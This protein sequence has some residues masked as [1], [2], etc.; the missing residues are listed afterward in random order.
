MGSAARGGS[1]VSTDKQAAESARAKSSNVQTPRI[2]NEAFNKQNQRYQAHQTARS[3]SGEAQNYS[4]TGSSG[5]GFDYGSE[6]DAYTS[7]NSSAEV[8]S[9]VSGPSSGA[10]TD[11]RTAAPSATT[12]RSSDAQNAN[13]SG[14]SGEMRKSSDK[15][16]FD[17]DRCDISSMTARNKKAGAADSKPADMSKNSANMGGASSS[18]SMNANAKSDNKSAKSGG[19]NDSTRN[20]APGAAPRRTVSSTASG[21]VNPQHDTAQALRREQQQQQQQKEQA[22]SHEREFGQNSGGMGGSSYSAQ[23]AIDKLAREQSAHAPN[24]EG[25]RGKSWPQGMEA[26][27]WWAVD[28]PKTRLEYQRAFWVA[29]TVV[30][31]DKSDSKQQGE[32]A[33]DSAAEAVA[34]ATKTVKNT[35]SRAAERVGDAIKPEARA[36]AQYAKANAQEAMKYAKSAASAT[37][38]AA[39]EAASDLG[40]AAA[41][42]ASSAAETVKETVKSTVSDAAHKASSAAESVKDNVK[43]TVADAAHGVADAAKSA[44]HAGESVLHSASDAVGRAASKV[45]S[46]VHAGKDKIEGAAGAVADKVDELVNGPEHKQQKASTQCTRSAG[47]SQEMQHSGMK[48]DEK[49]HMYKPDNK[50]NNTSSY[51]GSTAKRM[52]SSYQSAGSSQTAGDKSGHSDTGGT[53]SGYSGSDTSDISGRDKK[54]DHSSVHMRKAHCTD[55]WVKKSGLNPK[56]LRDD[57]FHVTE[58]ERSADSSG[59]SPAYTDSHAV[60]E[61]GSESAKPASA[62][63]LSASGS[64]G[65][66]SVSTGA[67]ADEHALA[68]KTADAVANALKD[69]LNKALNDPALALTAAQGVV[70]VFSGSNKKGSVADIV[71]FFTGTSDADKAGKVSHTARAEAIENVLDSFAAAAGAAT[72]RALKTTIGGMPRAAQASFF[73]NNVTRMIFDRIATTATQ[74]LKDTILG[75]S[76]TPS[77]V[78]VRREVAAPTGSTDNSGASTLFSLIPSSVVETLAR[79]AGPAIAVALQTA[80]AASLFGTRAP[81]EGGYAQPSQE[82]LLRLRERVPSPSTFDAAFDAAAR[83]VTGVIKQSFQSTLGIGNP[84][85]N[86]EDNPASFANNNNGAWT[87]Y[88]SANAAP[89]MSAFAADALN[90]PYDTPGLSTRVSS[91]NPGGFII[92]KVAS[93]AS[94]AINKVKSTI[95][96]A[97]NGSSSKDDSKSNLGAGL[98]KRPGAVSGSQ[99][100]ADRDRSPRRSFATRA[101]SST[102]SNAASQQ[103]NAKEDNDSKEDMTA[104]VSFNIAFNIRGVPQQSMPEHGKPGLSREESARLSSSASSAEHV[105]HNV[106]EHTPAS[107]TRSSSRGRKSQSMAQ[108]SQDAGI[109]IGS[110]KR[111]SYR[112]LSS[113]PA[114]DSMGSTSTARGRSRSPTGTR[115]SERTGKTGSPRAASSTRRYFSSDVGGGYAEGYISTNEAPCSNNS[116]ISGSVNK[117]AGASAESVARQSGVRARDARSSGARDVNIDPSGTGIAHGHMGASRSGPIKSPEP[118][119]D[120]SNS[121]FSGG[122]QQREMG[123]ESNATAST[124]SNTASYDKSGSGAGKGAFDPMTDPGVRKRSGMGTTGSMEDRSWD[125]E[126]QMQQQSPQ[127]QSEKAGQG[128]QKTQSTSS[129]TGKSPQQQQGKQGQAMGGKS[130][131]N[132]S[133][134]KGG[135][136]SGSMRRFSTTVLA[137]A[138]NQQERHEVAFTERKKCNGVNHTIACLIGTRP[139]ELM[140]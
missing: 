97:I 137:V 121:S 25:K 46:A 136:D 79:N 124:K 95:S 43:S 119:A 13:Q 2:D 135:S 57:V 45:A 39:G 118:G 76:N 83:A 34:D 125:K 17:T 78:N 52:F 31:D 36:Q 116:G 50:S 12:M 132:T 19:F 62:D 33:I 114:A 8:G 130:S 113:P 42:K 16:A 1:S 77:N 32:D 117:S 66:D 127:N 102:A 104:P 22:T 65:T 111:T 138:A 92:D 96:D 129:S 55:D 26:E 49:T 123:K 14:S 133:E 29:S 94:D 112:I 88:W 58:E 73:D 128:A 82:Q 126:H 23:D 7:M 64:T 35:V 134:R 100:V 20:M 110:G 139:C 131:S 84:N 44:K 86:N 67:T 108:D 37:A 61:K 115:A 93:A 54:D 98:G 6:S 28:P 15:T 90:R 40:R 59:A 68:S 109:I 63:K 51:T 70:G 120:R 21:P 9:G 72:G 41:D 24:A 60:S 3:S 4:R 105:D 85:I 27:S 80:L 5:D 30:P 18:S 89:H 101:R 87:P 53:T 107:T 56:N 103:G 69:T 74:T 71:S 81:T 47:T 38:T 48:Y 122:H 11:K 75:H 140:H 99:A 106:G 91:P 10:G